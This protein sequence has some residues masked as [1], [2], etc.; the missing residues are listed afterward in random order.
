MPTATPTRLH[1]HMA[2]LRLP[3]V[4]PAVLAPA[5]AVVVLVPYRNTVHAQLSGC[6]LYLLLL[7]A[8]IL[9]Y[10]KGQCGGS[11]YSGPTQ[12]V[13]GST[14]VYQK[15]VLGESDDDSCNSLTSPQRVVFAMSLIGRSLVPA[16]ESKYHIHMFSSLHPAYLEQQ[17][18]K[19][20]REVG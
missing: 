15:Y 20:F 16:R 19:W 18:M 11:S 12:C 13:S 17:S 10:I 6:Y 7:T 3:P 4:A 8:L 5:A 1:L 2:R 14:C 9:A